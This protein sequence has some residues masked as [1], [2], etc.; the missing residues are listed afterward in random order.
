MALKSQSIFHASLK[1]KEINLS[2]AWPQ[3]EMPAM[4]ILVKFQLA[5]VF[6]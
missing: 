1:E 5:Y 4:R 2:A 6:P 3:K